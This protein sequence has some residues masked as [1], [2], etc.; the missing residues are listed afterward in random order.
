MWKKP[1]GAMTS[2]GLRR[3][4]ASPSK[5][6]TTDP[7]FIRKGIRAS[8]TLPPAGGTVA[9]TCHLPSFG[10]AVGSPTSKPLALPVSASHSLSL[11]RVISS[12]S[13]APRSS[14]NMVWPII[15]LMCGPSSAG[16]LA[17]TILS[18]HRRKGRHTRRVQTRSVQVHKLES[19]SSRSESPVPSSSSGSPLSSSPCCPSCSTALPNP[20][21][22]SRDRDSSSTALLL[23]I[24][25]VP[26]PVPLPVSL[27]ES[28]NLDRFDGRSQLSLVSR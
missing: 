26:V 7:N 6:I 17:A 15:G 21:V 20:R 2:G 1:M 25:S 3:T 13:S 8:G 9:I 4:M 11:R 22:S 18:E 23:L 19:T 12:A 16:T 24:L 28:E 27:P 14:P 5:A 10:L